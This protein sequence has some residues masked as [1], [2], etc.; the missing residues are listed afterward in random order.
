MR[1]K[2]IIQEEVW[3]YNRVF[4]RERRTQPHDNSNA[5]SGVGKKHSLYY[6]SCGKER[7]WKKGNLHMRGRGRQSKVNINTP[8]GRREGHRKSS[9]T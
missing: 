8:K 3:G 9:Y 6:L 5:K 1:V 7:I 4:P 2:R